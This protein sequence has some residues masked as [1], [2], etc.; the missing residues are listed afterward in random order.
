MAFDTHK[1]CIARA[2]DTPS[3]ITLARSEETRKG[4]VLSVKM[5]LVKLDM[6]LNVKGFVKEHLDEIP[7]LLLSPEFGE[8]RL[9]DINLICRSIATSRYPKAGLF[10]KM[11]V[12]TFFQCVRE[13]MADDE[14]ITAREYHNKQGHVHNEAA[15]EVINQLPE[16]LKKEF[17]KIGKGQKIHDAKI[18]MARAMERLKQEKEATHDEEE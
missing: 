1:S 14:R 10:G 18:S 7:S 15:L 2:Y 5:M 13:Y 8:L 9:N 16:E 3:I 4:Y 6:L 12:Q 17:K 11:D